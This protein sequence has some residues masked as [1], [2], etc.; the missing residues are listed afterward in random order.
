M[1][2]RLFLVA[3]NRV[4]MSQIIID[5]TD[6]EAQL[7]ITCSIM[8]E[9]GIETAHL[10]HSMMNLGILSLVV[11]MTVCGR[12]SFSITVRLQIASTTIQ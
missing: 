6:T 2:R 4:N 1:I 11:P 8:Y 9:F 10:K 7:L 3:Q 5:V 12:G